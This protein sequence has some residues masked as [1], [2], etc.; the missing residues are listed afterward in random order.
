[1]KKTLILISKFISKPYEQYIE[2][3]ENI[4]CNYYID[5]EN[6]NSVI[7]DCINDYHVKCCLYIC[8]A[9]VVGNKID[10]YI[11][12]GVPKSG[13]ELVDKRTNNIGMGI[14]HIHLPDSKVFLWYLT[15]SERGFFIK[16][17]Y[18]THPPANDDYI[19]IAK[20]IYNDVDGFNISLNKY[21][22]Q[23]TYLLNENLKYLQTFES[24]N[25][26][27]INKS[28]KY[29]KSF[30]ENNSNETNLILFHGSSTNNII[31]DFHDNLF[32]TVND[33]IAA[34]YAYNLG[35]LMYEIKINLN[36]FIIEEK[37]DNLEKREGGGVIGGTDQELIDLLD[38]LGYNKEI[39]TNGWTTENPIKLYQRI[40]LSRGFSTVINNNFEPLIKYAKNL[41]Y[42]SLKFRDED[43]A[44]YI[45]DDTYIIFDG[46]KIKNIMDVYDVDWGEY[47]DVKI[48]SR[49]TGKFRK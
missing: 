37:W 5:Y 10:P 47:G 34:S 35:G 23:A 45:R 29:L 25:F 1:M 28:F 3:F 32:W 22:Y 14:Y 17:K 49:K 33:Y 30:N 15:W 26:N 41:G 7:N 38:K 6:L 39:T 24:F 16:M 31:T 12:T 27:K 18:I 19:S 48:K 44:A 42:D 20:E 13:M 8:Y 43:Y 40:A 36:P 46:S 4:A 21:F 2:D 11:S 9:I